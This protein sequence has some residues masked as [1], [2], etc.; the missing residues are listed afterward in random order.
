MRHP[1]KIPLSAAG[2]ATFVIVLAIALLTVP[3]WASFYQVTVFRDALIFGVFALSLD[4][5]WGKAGIPSFGH[6]AFFGLGGYFYAIA[7]SSL[8]PS[9]GSLVGA[10]G[11]VAAGAGVGLFL[12][13]FLLR[14]G[15]RGS[16][17]L[18]VTVALTQ[19]ARQV[20][21]SW[22]AVTGG[23]A[24]LVSVPPLG[25]SIFSSDY[26]LL[27]PTNQYFFTLALS[28]LA[29]GG[30]WWLGR[31]HYGRLLAAIANDENRAQTLGVNSAWQLTTALAISTSMA[32]LAGAVYVSMVGVM[33]PDLI[34]PLFSIEVVAWVLVGGMGTLLGPF[35]GTFVV[36]RLSQEISSF[37]PRLW[38]LAIGAFF[39]SMP[40]LF[41]NGIVSVGK[42][43]ALWLRGRAANQR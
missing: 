2:R 6:A 10:A 29:I 25:F 5:L 15:V 9:F 42:V 14:A 21:I 41:Q 8:N 28:F 33:V 40:F 30:L 11:A 24:G 31:G 27:D 39:V 23:D 18:I 22:S 35:V 20:A 19:I 12:G 4:F 7:A 16:L 37:D 17:F 43:I 3:V 26:V 32:A 1:S 13:A 38:P 34:G 36:W